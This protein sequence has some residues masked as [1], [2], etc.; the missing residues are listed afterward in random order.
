MGPGY[1]RR[2]LDHVIINVSDYDGARAFYEQALDPLGVGVIIEADQMCGFGEDGKPYLWIAERGEASSPVHVA[3]AAVDHPAVDAFHAAA[4]A[5]GGTENGP[6]GVRPHYHRNY[7]G[8]FV[9][10]ADGN[11]IEAVC[12]VPD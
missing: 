1:D 6:P 11:N 7:Y 9:L 12:H 4:I 10:D 5:D 3:L 8:A 2:V